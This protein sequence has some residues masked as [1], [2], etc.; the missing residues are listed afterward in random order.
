MHGRLLVLP[1]DSR[2]QPRRDYLE[3]RFERFKRRL[4]SA[5]FFTGS[6]RHSLISANAD[7]S[8]VSSTNSVTEPVVQPQVLTVFPGVSRSPPENRP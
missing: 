3:E 5:F 4:G 8:G 6:F 1:R 7:S 2:L